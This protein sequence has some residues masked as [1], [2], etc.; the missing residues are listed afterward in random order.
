MCPWTCDVPENILEHQLPFCCDVLCWSESFRRQPRGLNTAACQER[1]WNTGSLTEHGLAQP[2]PSRA[3][4]FEPGLLSAEKV[5][6]YLDL[7]RFDL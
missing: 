7:S 5:S 1:L 2:L 4:L 6:L 3:C